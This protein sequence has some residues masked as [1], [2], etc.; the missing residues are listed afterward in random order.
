MSVRKSYELLFDG[1]SVFSG[2]YATVQSCY[3]AV[4]NVLSLLS[5]DSHTLVIAFHPVAVKEVKK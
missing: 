1:H 5:D 2:S 3:Y 4:L